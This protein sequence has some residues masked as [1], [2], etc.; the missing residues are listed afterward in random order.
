MAVRVISVNGNAF[1]GFDSVA[2]KLRTALSLYGAAHLTIDPLVNE[3]F[4]IQ[5]MLCFVIRFKRKY[6]AGDPRKKEIII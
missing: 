1:G 3:C 2:D 6:H 4:S 5:K